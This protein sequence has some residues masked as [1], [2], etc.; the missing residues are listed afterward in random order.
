MQTD[1]TGVV[2]SCYNLG[3]FAGALAAMRF[4]QVFGR[5]RAIF[6]G[7]TFV[8][9]GAILQFSSF[10]LAQFI[11]GRLIC[12]FGTGINTYVSFLFINS[13]QTSTRRSV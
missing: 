13:L 1:V 6:I 5:R 10:G 7:C 9:I 11:V 3:C 12:G 2:I 8:T 4:G